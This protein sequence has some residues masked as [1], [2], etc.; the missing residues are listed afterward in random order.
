M[1][2]KGTA[3]GGPHLTREWDGG[4][5]VPATSGDRSA[6]L[7][8]RRFLQLIGSAGG[9]AAVMN[10]LA[11]W[12]L[13]GASAQETPPDL[14]GG[15]QGTKVIVIGAGAGGCGAAYELARH[16]YD[17]RVLEARDYVGGH[18]FTVRRGSVSHEYGGERQVC[19]FDEG[20]WFDAGASRIPYFH[21]GILYYCKLFNIPLRAHENLDLNCFVYAEDIPGPLSGKAIRLREMQ[22]DMDGYTAELLAKVVNQNQLDLALSPD[23]RDRLLDYLIIEGLLSP[24]DLTYRGSSHRGYA[25]YPGA[26]NQPGEPSPPYAFLDLLPFAQAAED[27]NAGDLAGT[28]VLDW[29]ETLLKPVNG[30]GEIYRHG[31]Q[32]ALGDRITLNAEVKE[33]RQDAHSVRVVYADSQTGQTQALTADYCLCTIPLSVLMHIPADFSGPMQEAIRGVAYAPAGKMGLQMKRRF[34]EEDDWI[35]GGQS[36]LNQGQIRVI[37]YPDG[38]YNQTGKGILLG[39]YNSYMPSLEVSRLSLQD[40]IE[41]AL[42]YGSKLHAAY[43]QEFETG[44]SVAWHRM[45]YSLGAWPDYSDLSRQQYY[46]RLLEPDGRIYL[47]GEHLSYILAW[48]EGAIQAAW[49]QIEKLHERVMQST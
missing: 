23:D 36:F 28:A 14:G 48:Q 29:Q 39:Y 20:L 16:G 45:P 32:P 5:A 7:T 10:T 6:A 37:G 44:F 42:S 8:R 47:V 17:V 26:G 9:A 49:L 34:W 46:P 38:G 27:T 3:A 30:M 19:D 33:I 13:L 24:V 35:Y 1:E 12:G 40:R 4:M 41:L 31:F 43:R 22:T 25:V 2:D 18:V 21:R 11:A 15:G